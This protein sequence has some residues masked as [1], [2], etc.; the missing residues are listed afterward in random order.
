[1][2]VPHN[3]SNFVVF[4]SV[5]VLIVMSM[6]RFSSQLSFCTVLA[7]LLQDSTCCVL[8]DSILHT[9]LGTC[10]FFFFSNMLSFEPVI[11]YLSK[12]IQAFS[13][14]LHQP[15]FISA[16]LWCSVLA[17]VFQT[18]RKLSVIFI[19]YQWHFCCN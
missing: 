9:W 14:I 13:S 10:I 15:A 4:Q 6:C 5:I 16:A 18:S 2:I 1:M 8:R 3:F 12:L 19:A 7:H 11:K 17:V